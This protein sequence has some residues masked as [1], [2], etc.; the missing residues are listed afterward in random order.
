MKKN[1]SKI[2]IL[3]IV[4]SQTFSACTPEALNKT[5]ESVLQA[6]TEVPLT[7]EDII[8]GLKEALVQGT[9]NGTNLVSATDGYYKNPSIKI[10]FPP[11]AQKVEQALKDIGL[12]SLTESLIEKVNRAAEDAAKEATPI[13]KT[14]ITSMTISDAMNILMGEDTA[15]T[16]YLRKTTSQELYNA[17]EPVIVK[18]L[19]NR[20]ALNAWT[21]VITRYN[22]IPLTKDVNPS[23]QNYVTNRAIDGIFQMIAKEEMLIR[24][25]PIARTTDI[26]KR[27][28]A[29][30]DK[31]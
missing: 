6:T 12:S 4:L 30:Q 25:D 31:K 22:K 17:F 28:F 19:N 7:Q 1:A 20:G 24:K 13:F 27:V 18:H 8:K 21:D 26:L 3:L 15:A 5:L 29:K 11:E 16:A 10:L 14:A 23:L 2:I 9:V